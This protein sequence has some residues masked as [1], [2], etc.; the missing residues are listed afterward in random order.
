MLTRDPLIKAQHFQDRAQESLGRA[1]C[2]RTSSDCR[3]HLAL[4]RH[5]LLMGEAELQEASKLLAKRLC[6][7]KDRSNRR[8]TLGQNRHASLGQ[9]SS[10]QN[11]NVIVHKLVPLDKSKSHQ[12]S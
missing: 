4:A 9:R 5:Y 10:T 8:K 7:A 11:P 12:N 3:H 2:A 1:E 6:G